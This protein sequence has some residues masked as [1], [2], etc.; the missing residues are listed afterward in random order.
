MSLKVKTNAGVVQRRKKSMD[1]YYC[2]VFKMPFC[3][4]M[5]VLVLVVIISNNSNN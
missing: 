3:H 5:F 2:S 4:A 1:I